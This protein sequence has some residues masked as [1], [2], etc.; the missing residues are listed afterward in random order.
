MM[1]GEKLKKSINDTADE[2]CGREGIQPKKKWMTQEIL[3]KM[4]ERRLQKDVNVDR[5]R[6][7]NRNIKRMCKEAK[8]RFFDEKCKKIQ[9]L[10][11]RHNP[12]M[13]KII[14]D[15]QPSNKKEINAIRDEHGRMLTRKEEVLQ[16]FAEY[17]EELYEDNRDQSPELDLEEL[18]SAKIMNPIGEAEVRTII[19]E[20]KND[21]ANGVDE[22][23]AEM[24]KCLGDTGIAAITKMINKI[25]ITGEI[26]QDFKNSI[27]IPIPND[28]KAE[29]C[30]QFRIISLITHTSK[31][32]LQ[33]IKKRITPII[34]RKL[35][36]NQMGFRKG[37]GTREGIF[38]VRQL[39]E[40]LIQM[41][42][43]LYMAFIDYSKAFDRVQHQK[44]M[45]VMKRTGI[46]ELERRLIANLYWGQTAVVKIGSD[47]SES[48]TVEKE[49]RQGCIL[50]PILLICKLTI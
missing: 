12:L 9:E 49:V 48:F 10:D 28:K 32:L 30:T 25:Y 7:I 14:K 6:E 34:E 41:N 21:K 43:K 37:R 20:L 26:P 22:I 16:R 17:I 45:E 46:P 50:L 40:R 8:E 36:E 19:R 42:R 15:M 24:L 33:V 35:S 3:E 44:L 4:E 23:P 38:Q 18:Q 27:F 39:G 13:Y 5:Y 47:I 11:E 2:I 31:I 1:Q 29:N